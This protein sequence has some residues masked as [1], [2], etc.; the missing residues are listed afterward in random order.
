[1][2]TSFMAEILTQKFGQKVVNVALFSK[3]IGKYFFLPFCFG[4]S[5]NVSKR[6]SR[7]R[8][9]CPFYYHAWNQT[10]AKLRIPS[11]VIAYVNKLVKLSKCSRLRLEISLEIKI[12][13]CF[14]TD[15]DVGI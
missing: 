11:S 12:Q 2:F 5:S 7:F 15:V 14:A 6:F 10:N 13:K 9:W 3:I 1:M 8:L 4:V